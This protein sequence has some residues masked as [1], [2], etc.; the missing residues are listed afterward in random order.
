MMDTR[1]ILIGLLTGGARGHARADAE[2]FVDGRISSL[3]RLAPYPDTVFGPFALT[4]Q[5]KQPISRLMALRA[6][7]SEEGLRG[8][9]YIPDDMG[10]SEY[11]FH[12]DGGRDIR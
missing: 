5:R 3:P 11:M 12:P 4:L 9:G 1:E 10:G 8:A 6:G 7:I 2:A